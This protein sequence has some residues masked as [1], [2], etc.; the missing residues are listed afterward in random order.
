MKIFEKKQDKN[1]IISTEYHILTYAEE[2]FSP[3]NIHTKKYDFPEIILKE[4]VNRCN[5]SDHVITM[6]PKC[7]LSMLPRRF[8][9]KSKDSFEL[10]AKLLEFF[11]LNALEINAIKF[12]FDF[13][14]HELPIYILDAIY[15][16][17]SNNT[18]CDIEEIIIIQK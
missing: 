18:L 3:L 7:N 1:T 15:M 6:L 13:R 11:D 2:G 14:T 5:E 9:R 10:H 12:I 8:I 17:D 4:Y 16:L